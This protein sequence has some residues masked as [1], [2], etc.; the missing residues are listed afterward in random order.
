MMNKLK[1]L[2]AG[3][4]ML[5]GV[6][7]GHAST[8]LRGT[9]IDHTEVKS[10]S[11]ILFF[12]RNR[13]LYANTLVHPCAGLMSAPRGIT[14]EPTSPATDELCDNLGTFRVNE[15]GQVCMWGA[16]TRLPDTKRIGG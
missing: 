13:A 14:Y 8:C 2:L 15:T 5:L 4:V 7:T 10:D 9:E 11:T 6:Q 3:V 16:F 1:L 12:M